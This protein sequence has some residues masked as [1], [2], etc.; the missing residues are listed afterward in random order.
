MSEGTRSQHKRACKKQAAELRDEFLFKQPESNH[1]GDC[2]ICCL[3]LL[4]DEHKCLMMTCCSKRICNCC[5]Y[6]TQMREL[7]GKLQQKCP[8]CQRPVPKTK[9]QVKMNNLKRVTAIDPIAMCQ[10]GSIR[11]NDGDYDTAF[12]YWTKATGLG[13]VG[14]HYNL[15]LLYKKGC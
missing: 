9:E 10:M 8:F 4:I 3:P 14:S 5:D 13:D 15:S 2:P 12:E 7:D 6:A 11:F 1:Y